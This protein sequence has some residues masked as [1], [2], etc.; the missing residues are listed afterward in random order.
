MNISI[1]YAG[2]VPYA[3]FWTAIDQ[4]HFCCDPKDLAENKCSREQQMVSRGQDLQIIV[5][6]SPKFGTTIERQ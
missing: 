4:E 6:C 5:F 3:D 2:Q 1:E